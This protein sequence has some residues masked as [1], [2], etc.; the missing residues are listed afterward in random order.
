VIFRVRFR[1]GLKIC[2]NSSFFKGPL[3]QSLWRPDPVKSNRC[4][5]PPSGN[6]VVQV[7]GFYVQL[8][9]DM[10][11]RGQSKASNSQKKDERA[12]PYLEIQNDQQWS[13]SSTHKITSLK[14]QYF[15]HVS[16]HSSLEKDI[17]LGFMPGTKRQGGQKR[18]WIDNVT[19]WTGKGLVDI[20]RL[21]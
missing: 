5:S 12:R 15:G 18:Q 4:R 16:R 13:E 10:W 3:L 7:P 17:M 21:A 1:L 14:L 6:Q 19:K 11:W 20:V 8:K 9:G 2:T